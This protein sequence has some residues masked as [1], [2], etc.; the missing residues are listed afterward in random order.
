MK[1]DIDKWIV[2]A[3]SGHNDGWTK[4]HYTE[5]L[6]EIK[7]R[8]NSLEFLNKDK[9]KEN[10]GEKENFKEAPSIDMGGNYKRD[11]TFV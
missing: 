2:E 8:L 9:I 6:L 1:Y 3:T 7:D 5:Q 4:L 10:Y 11:D